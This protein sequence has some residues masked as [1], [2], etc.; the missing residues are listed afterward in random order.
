MKAG[1]EKGKNFLH[2]KFLARLNSICYH[3]VFLTIMR[4]LK[5]LAALTRQFNKS[6][7]SQLPVM[8]QILVASPPS[9]QGILAVSL[10]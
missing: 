9:L 10:G 3:T 6:G 7:F 4:Y 1:S 2:A 5:S 8:E